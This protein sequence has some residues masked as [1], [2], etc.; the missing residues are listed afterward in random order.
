[1][2][3]M[4]RDF[5]RRSKLLEFGPAIECL[6]QLR[7]G[8]AS[9]DKFIGK[10]SDLGI[11]RRGRWSAPSSLRRY[12]KHGRVQA[13]L[14]KTTASLRESG[15]MVLKDFL[16]LYSKKQ[17]KPPPVMSLAV[18]RGSCKRNLSSVSAL[19]SQGKVKLQHKLA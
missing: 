13:M 16:L 8:G 18:Q 17:F 12:E 15:L 19:S 2:M 11:Q 6:Y 3:E 5:E 14:N 1:M 9:H 10:R 4:M 7:H